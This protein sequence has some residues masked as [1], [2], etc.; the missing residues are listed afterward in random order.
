MTNFYDPI[1]TA[2]LANQVKNFW[3][4]L[5]EALDDA[6]RS[7]WGADPGNYQLARQS[8]RAVLA[9]YEPFA[10]LIDDVDDGSHLGMRMATRG[11][12]SGDC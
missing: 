4:E 11:W 9:K 7:A 10:K 6:E 5:R 12:T 3:I 2:E 1:E 8:V